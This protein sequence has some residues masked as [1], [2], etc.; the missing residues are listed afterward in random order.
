MN[1]LNITVNNED[2]KATAYVCTAIPF[3]LGK[4]VMTLGVADI[5][6][7]NI[8]SEG[9]LGIAL[10]RHKSGDWGNICVEDKITNDEATRIGY[11]NTHY[12]VSAFG[13]LLRETEA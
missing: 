5:I 13:S 8:S 3:E 6:E 2:V 7:N 10:V 4:A 11:L 1:A 9:S 12:V